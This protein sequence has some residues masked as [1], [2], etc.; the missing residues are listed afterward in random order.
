M[1]SPISAQYVTQIISLIILIDNCYLTLK[2]LLH[3][4]VE[5]SIEN[6][7]FKKLCNEQCIF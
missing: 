4:Q 1:W 7:K 3:Q 5:T 6:Y 2:Y